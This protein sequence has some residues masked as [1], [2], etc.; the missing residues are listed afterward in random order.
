MLPSSGNS[1]AFA[2]VP[3]SFDP[4]LSTLEVDSTEKNAGRFVVVTVTPEDIFG[5]LLGAGQE[6]AVFLDGT[7]EDIYGPIEVNDTGRWDLYCL[8]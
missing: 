3:S 1:A 7:A 2:I 8:N 5:N 6:V 4:A